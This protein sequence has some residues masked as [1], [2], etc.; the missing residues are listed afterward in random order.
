MVSMTGAS[1]GD[2]DYDPPGAELAALKAG[3]EVDKF[4][5]KAIVLVPVFVAVVLAITYAIVT[6]TFSAI[7]VKP[8]PENPDSPETKERVKLNQAPIND[9]FARTSSTDPK[10]PPGHSGDVVPQPRLEGLNETEGT[11]PPNYQSRLA[12]PTG[13]SPII[14]PEDLRPDRYIDPTTRQKVL[15]EYGWR[16]KEK[17]T[18]YIPIALAMAEVLKTLPVSKTPVT[19]T[20]L[21][22]HKSKQ[23]NAGRGGPSQPVATPTPEIKKDH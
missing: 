9:R 6:V 8:T 11:G 22:D 20:G 18:A 2:H 17:K 14:H 23:S 16:D 15:I 13:N 3:H 12:L 7:N 1:A 5:V 19:V 10:N 4:G 21:S